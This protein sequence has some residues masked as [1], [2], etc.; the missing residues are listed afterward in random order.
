MQQNLKDAIYMRSS[1]SSQIGYTVPMS[2]AKRVN[3][4]A[5]LEAFEQPWSLD[6]P[7]RAGMS[8][9]AGQQKTTNV[10]A[11]EPDFFWGNRTLGS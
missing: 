8:Y 11:L 5:V 2:D 6:N 1:Q 7:G 3:G 4:S 10:L 9:S